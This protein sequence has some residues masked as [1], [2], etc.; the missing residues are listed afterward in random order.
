M[1]ERHLP[2]RTIELWE[3]DRREYVPVIRAIE[4]AD[5]WWELLVPMHLGSDELRYLYIQ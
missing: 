3:G 1:N 5:G 4:L 2:P